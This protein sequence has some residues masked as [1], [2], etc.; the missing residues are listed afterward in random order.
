MPQQRNLK[1]IETPV[2]RGSNL[3]GADLSDLDLREA[4]L[5]GAN[6]AYANLE[7]ANLSGVDLSGADL[8]G[9]RLSRACLIG[10][11]LTDA[12]LCQADLA[13]QSH[14]RVSKFFHQM[15][16]ATT[17]TSEE[18]QKVKELTCLYDPRARLDNAIC[19]ALAL[20]MR[21]CRTPIYVLPYWAART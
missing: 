6:L 14:P 11:N 7:D 4:S 8:T 5:S 17:F 3:E 18:R 15:A 19:A 1:S 13:L 10:A 16:Y 9:A 21:Y 12:I 2:E 20:L